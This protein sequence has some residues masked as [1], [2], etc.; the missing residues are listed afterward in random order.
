MRRTVAWLISAVTML[1]LVTGV[2]AWAA[3]PALTD[4]AGI[5][6]VAA[7]RLD[8]R[9]LEVTMAT[10]ALGQ[11]VRV[12]IL[13]PTGYAADPQRTYPVLYLLHGG[14]DD[15]RSWTDKGDAEAITAGLPLLVVMPDAG[16]G[17][18]YSNWYNLGAYGTPEWETFHIGRLI[19]WVEANF[20]T[21]AGPQGRA[22]AGLSMG[23]FGAMSY[24]ARHPGLFSSAMSFSG[25]VDTRQLPVTAVVDISPLATLDVPTAVWGLKLLNADIWRAHDPWEHAGDLAGLNL[26]IY[27]GNGL[28]GPYD[29]R[30]LPDSSVVTESAVQQ[31]S[32]ALH[33]KLTRLGIAH[34][35]RDYGP[36]THSWP[37][38]QRDL[39][40][41]LPSVM[42]A[43][44]T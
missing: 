11:D 40:W 1:S 6:V 42:Q 23:G 12:R 29:T 30:P 20:R 36:G 22:V 43:F 4:A 9:L 21:A 15:Y 39:R 37:Y 5:H 44:G 3:A 10:D 8:D 2:R 41:A 24:A 19:P 31:M 18:W 27:T 35:Y 38:W 17:G 34:V 16:P 28:P 32:R 14:T 13:Q 25:A 26:G 33:D 7:S